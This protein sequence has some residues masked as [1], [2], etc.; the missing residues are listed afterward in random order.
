MVKKIAVPMMMCVCCLSNVAHTQ[1]SA[2]IPAW[3]D[4][5]LEIHTISTGRGNCQYL[6]MPDGTTMMIDAGDFDGKAYDK[7][8]APM[9]CAPASTTTPAKI[10]AGYIN[11]LTG[12]FDKGIDYF[13][14]THFHTDHYGAVRDGLAIHPEGQ[15]FLTGLTELAEYIPIKRIVD[16]AYPAYDYPVRLAGRRLN[17]GTLLDPSFENYLK[18]LDFQQQRHAVKIEGF[19]VGSDMQFKLLNDPAKYPSC[20]VRNIKVNDRLWTG[21]DDNYISLWTVDELLGSNGKFSEN[22]LSCAIVVEYGDFRYYAGGDNTGLLDQ[23]HDTWCDLET[24]MA[25]IVGRVTAMSLNH[26][27]NRD[28]SNANFLNVLDPHIVLMQTWSSDHPGQEVSHRLISSNIGTRERELYM[29]SFDPLTGLG[30]GPWFEKKLTAANC[31]IVIRVYPDSSY[32]TYVV[33]T[34]SDAP[35]V[36]HKSALHHIDK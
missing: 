14:L 16:R 7:K 13:L 28:A 9:R 21:R 25:A 24:P 11:N 12:S 3:E 20:K 4:G 8:Y 29:T 18:F 23:D 1:T 27:G 36:L 32:E 17:N 6:I 26:H 19:E 2:A 5:I 35:T 34:Q 22:P 33:D 30:I 10:I 15:Y 31:H